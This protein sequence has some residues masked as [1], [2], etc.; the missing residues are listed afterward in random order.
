VK[1]TRPVIQ[2]IGIMGNARKREVVGVCRKML[3][4][5]KRRSL[6]AVVGKE[7][8]DKLGL[9]NREAQAYSGDIKRS[10]LILTL[11]GDGFLFSVVRNLYPCSVPLLHVNLGSLG[12]NAQA[13]AD[14]LFRMLDDL[15]ERPMACQERLILQGELWRKRKRLKRFY[16]LNDIVIQK[17]TESRI[18][19]LVLTIDGQ[20]VTE[21]RADGLIVA[22]P[23]GSTAYNLAAGGP[24]LHPG[25]EAIS[26]VGLCPHSISDR[27]LLVGPTSLLEIRFRKHKDREDAVVSVD[28]QEWHGLESDDL[29]RICAAPERMR[30]V[31][32]PTLS[33][34]Q[35]LREKLG[36]GKTL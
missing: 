22:T 29:V 23:T 4:W 19:H 15:R 27:A 25:V 12:Y 2:V 20:F 18:I 7:L 24:I 11:G 17:R 34:F 32:N 26:I 10:D 6:R 33:Y 5:C 14:E 1:K 8:L 36:W 9:S 28:C 21:Y 30:L 35:V 13:S 3:A 31:V 16:A